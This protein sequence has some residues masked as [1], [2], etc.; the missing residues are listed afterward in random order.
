MGGQS[1]N[2]RPGHYSGPGRKGWWFRPSSDSGNEEKKKVS[3]Q[4]L[5]VQKTLLDE[6]GVVHEGK[7]HK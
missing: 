7:N 2:R 5:E 6:L 1:R 3:L 4:I